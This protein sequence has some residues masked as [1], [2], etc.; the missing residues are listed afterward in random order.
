MLPRNH[1][2]TTMNH[3]LTNI[4]VYSKNKNADPL[5]AVMRRS[6]GPHVGKQWDAIVASVSEAAASARQ[7]AY[8]LR[9]IRQEKLDAFVL[10]VER[11]CKTAA[12]GD[13]SRW[14]NLCEMARNESK[15]QLRYQEATSQ[16]EKARER[17]KSVDSEIAESEHS[18]GGKGKRM[19]SGVSRALGN[20]FSILPDGG[21][22]AMQ[23]M[24]SDDARL[25]IAKTTLKEQR[26]KESK[27]KYALDAATASKAHSLKSYS[28][29]AENLTYAFKKEDAAGWIEVEGAMKSLLSAFDG[30]RSDRYNS[31]DKATGQSANQEAQFSDIAEWTARATSHIA[32]KAERSSNDEVKNTDT[33][34]YALKVELEDSKTV[35][36]LLL[37]GET[38]KEDSEQVT[39]ASDS[40]ATKESESSPTPEAPPIVDAN[41]LLDSPADHFPISALKKKLSSAE[42]KEL[43]LPEDTLSFDTNDKTSGEASSSKV[44]IGHSSVSAENSLFLS[45]FWQNR[46]ENEE[47]PSI[48]DSFSCAYW[49]KEGEGY[50]SPLLHGRLFLTSNTMYFIGW[51]D[52]K[53]VLDLADVTKVTKAKNL[54]GTIDNSLRV[55]YETENGESSYFFGSFAFRDNALQLLQQLSTVARSLRELNAPPKTEKAVGETA[56]PPVPHDQVIKKMEVVLSKKLKNVSIQRFYELI[57][58]E[59]NGDT[60]AKPFYGPWLEYMGS[61]KVKVGEWEVAK[62]ESDQFISQWCGEKYSQRRQ[63]SFEFTRTTHL[64]I[65]PPIAGVKQTHHCSV[66]G[67]DKCVLAMTVEMEGIPYADCFAVEVR[68]VARRVGSC[69]IHVEVGVFVDFKKSTMFAK[70]IRAGTLEETKPVHH[71]LFDS[72]KA[73]CMKEGGEPVATAEEE[74]EEE[75]NPETEVESKSAYLGILS[76]AKDVVMENKIM[77]LAGLVGFLLLRLLPSFFG[78]GASTSPDE[79]AILNQRIDE[80]HEEMREMRQTLDEILQILKEKN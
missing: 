66:D 34:G 5:S 8:D 74:E 42:I 26:Q 60:D 38:D 79:S 56:L 46:D 4:S 37:L 63:V 59:G 62:S 39:K 31:I 33:T 32:K 11:E 12:D 41:D 23:K 45:H 65:G 48:I 51:G 53:I 77:L 27:E 15:A 3:N 17:V 72:A 35:Y 58:S 24:L 71:K 14:R 78:R 1:R 75:A 76:S 52:K 10:K 29:K 47:P 73:L 67:N 21:E 49:P 25:Q 69:D 43:S 19:N 55:V 80:L 50:L 16:F 6:E 54:M 30:F 70:K 20:V 57:W 40:A 68:W 61:H 18:E 28:A 36:K 44:E 64:Y 7:L 2:L 13:D 9:L 22:Q